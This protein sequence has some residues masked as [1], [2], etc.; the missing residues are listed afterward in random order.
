MKEIS[1]KD[2]EGLKIGNA[3]NVQAGDLVVT[4]GCGDVNKLA[5]LI[6]KKLEEKE[7]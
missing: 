5:R 6:L 4:L 3:E 1:I 7:Q 2:F